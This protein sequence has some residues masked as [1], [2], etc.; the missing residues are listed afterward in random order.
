MRWPQGPAPKVLLIDIG[1]VVIHDPRP[2][3]VRAI[4]R[5]DRLNPRKLRE[6][7]YRVVRRLDTGSIGL[8][9]AYSA[10]RRTFRWSISFHEFRQLVGWDSL[11]AIPQVLPALRALHRKGTVRVLYASDIER[12]TWELLCRKFHLNDCA[13]GAVLSFR[14]RSMKPG[15]RFFRAALR[16]ARATPSEVVFLDD[17]AENVR[18]ARALGI[19]ARRVRSSQDT[20]E[21]L[22]ALGEPVRSRR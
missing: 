22:R 10:L 12:V 18:G 8:G 4:L 3:V 9:D 17:R 13:D 1:D 14:V 5:R 16:M 19:R 2:K 20:L 21:V 7:Y 15:R 6:A 11:E